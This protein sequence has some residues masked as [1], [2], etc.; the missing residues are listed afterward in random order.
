QY[1]TADGSAVAGSDYT[2]ESGSATIAEGGTSVTIGI[3]VA[4][5]DVTE[6]D[7]TFHVALSDISGATLGKA[8]GTGTIVNDD[9]T[10]VAIHAIQGSTDHS[11]LSGQQVATR[12]IVTGRKSS[13]F[14]LQAPDAEAD[15]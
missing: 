10:T 7:E 12:G 3:V 1:A 14:F 6:A 5:D 11:P 8:R 13:G 2:A 9:I 4:G 15:A